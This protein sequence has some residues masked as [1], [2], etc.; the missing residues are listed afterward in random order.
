M[1]RGGTRA[2]FGTTI[3]EVLVAIGLMGVALTVAA[4][5]FHEAMHLELLEEQYHRHSRQCAWFFREFGREVRAARGFAAHEGGHHSGERVL[6]LRRDDGVTVLAA[7]AGRV[8]RI[9]IGKDGA[10]RVTLLDLKDLKEAV[11]AFDFEGATPQDARAVVV[12]V[13]WQEHHDSPVKD[14]VLSLRA[15]PRR[16]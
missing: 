5:Y 12:T 15:A 3:A 2:R 4:V 1:R 16:R 10:E 7:E 13:R 6:I 8:D 11:V 14:P 9:R